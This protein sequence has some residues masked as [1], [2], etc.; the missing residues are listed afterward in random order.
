MAAEPNSPAAADVDQPC[1]R[2]FQ[3]RWPTLKLPLRPD[4][5][6]AAM[7]EAQLPPPGAG[8]TLL[9]GVTPELA[10]LDRTIIAV[11]WSEEMVSTA[12]PGDTD[13]RQVVIGDWKAMPLADA[14]MAA[15]MSDGAFTMLDWPAQAPIFLQQ[16]A[17]VLRPGGRAAI[18]CFASPEPVPDVAAVRRLALSGGIGFHLF[19]LMFNMA[20]AREGSRGP[21]SLTVSSATLFERFEATFPDRQVLS[22]A[23]GWPLETIAEIDA[24]RQSRYIH[25]YPARREL[26]EMAACYWP[27]SSHFVETTGYPG[28]ELCPILVLERQ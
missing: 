4:A 13:R 10:K 8:M 6:V 15:A 18:R 7:V 9:L 2:D 3:L 28:A 17:R 24:Y 12:W 16:L 19:K 14:A 25:C 5:S 22:L 23:S 21:D 27:G 26:A 20:V 11:D 1:I